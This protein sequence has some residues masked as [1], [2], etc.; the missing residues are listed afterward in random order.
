MKSE[1]EMLA[2]RL[3]NAGLSAAAYHAGLTRA[4]RHR[5]QA[6][7]MCG[8]VAVIVAT[9]AFGMG[10]DKSDVRRVVHWQVPRSIEDY[11]QEVGR[12][13]RDG[14]DAE[15]VVFFDAADCQRLLSLARGDGVEEPQVRRLLELLPADRLVGLS[16]AATSRELDMREA[17]IETLLVDLAERGALELLPNGFCT[18]DVALGSAPSDVLVEAVRGCGT[19]QPNASYRVALGDIAARVGLETPSEC[20]FTQRRD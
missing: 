15:C 9:V 20:V 10:L 2:E 6:E 16:L 11:V 5:T 18:C 13:G 3:R 7:F 4:L 8:K 12:A 19:L 17:V 14:E 1:T